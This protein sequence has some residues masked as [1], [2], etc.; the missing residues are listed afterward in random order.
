MNNELIG[1]LETGAEW[2]YISYV[3]LDLL[4]I[5]NASLSDWV[6]Y[7][8]KGWCGKFIRRFLMR[9]DF[10]EILK[11]LEKGSGLVCDCVECG[12]FRAT[13]KHVKLGWA[14]VASACMSVC[15]CRVG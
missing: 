10:F 14:G 15:V 3:V 1:L 2:V 9:F 5:K 8:S 12:Y 4:L 11:I 7:V 13:S 6:I